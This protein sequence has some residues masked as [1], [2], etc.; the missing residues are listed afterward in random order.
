M[1]K[2]SKTTRAIPSS[3]LII[4][5]DSPNWRR[6]QGLL[7]DDLLN[8]VS[9]VNNSIDQD[10]LYIDPSTKKISVKSFKLKESVSV[11]SF[12]DQN[13]NI[14]RP[15]ETYAVDTKLHLAID[16]NY[17]YVWSKDKWKRV[18]LAEF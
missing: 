7:I 9:D 10:T 11:V 8:Y 13:I 16:Q 15:P 3:G 17:L 4:P 14:N 12:E 5:V 6:P 1:E 2:F 18:P